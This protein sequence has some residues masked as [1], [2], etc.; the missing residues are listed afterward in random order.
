MKSRS[1]GYLS[2]LRYSLPWLVRC[3]FSRARSL[4]REKPSDPKC[5]IFTIANHFEPSWKP[6]GLLDVDTQRRRVDNYYELARKTGE[7]VR[8]VDGTK[9]RHTNFYPGEQYDRQILEK[10]AAMQAEG[11]GEVEV[12]LHHGVDV[13][14][15]AENLRSALTE[16]RD[17][18]S[19][20]HKCLSRMDG[21]GV[22]MYAFVHGNN[23]LANSA[24]GKYC[25][26]DNEMEILRET[27][28]YVDMTLPSAPDR[29]QVP[30][31]NQIYECGLPMSQKAPH[32]KGKR[33][34]ALGGPL[35]LPIIFTG[36][37]VLD[38]DD[39]SRR[40][41][42]PRID[43]GELD[44]NH[45]GD[46]TRLARWVGTNI[47]VDGQPDWVF[48]KLSCHGFVDRDQQACI[49]EDAK[50]FFSEVIEN[51]E[52][53]NDYKVVFATAREA[54]NMVFAAMDGMTGS[55]G[56]FR[57]YRLKPLMREESVFQAPS[58]LSA[59]SNK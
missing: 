4:F 33:V 17:V 10:L 29:S 56:H 13:P 38:W 34:R 49:G 8:D 16:F 9:F 28:C 3:P 2:K 40:M 54:C 45:S 25:G 15:T 31:L 39:W 30:M 50:R 44:G 59:A 14:D 27:G 19:S 32:R 58:V 26:V 24:G 43:N 47:T 23:A 12:H 6:D 1:G 20:E 22:P 51:G 35:Q 53:T 5:I 57:N 7:S 55:P 48:V 46:P 52:K 41:M 36:P 21:T 42:V 37:L 11:L 18:L